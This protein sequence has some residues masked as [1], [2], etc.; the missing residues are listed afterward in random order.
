MSTSDE[1]GLP[2]PTSIAERRLLRAAKRGDRAAQAELLRR[3]EPLVRHIAR[4]LYLPGGDADDLAQS[5]RLGIVDAAR[6]WD[7]KRPRAVQVLRVALC[8]TRGPHGRQLRPRRQ[9]P[10]ASTAPAR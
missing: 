8:H 4:T 5:A 7:P 1:N 3:Y 9:A 10:T 2:A 6:A